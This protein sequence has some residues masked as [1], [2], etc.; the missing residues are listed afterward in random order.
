MAKADALGMDVRIHPLVVGRTA[1]CKPSPI[2]ALCC[3]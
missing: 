3:R 1:P 2:A